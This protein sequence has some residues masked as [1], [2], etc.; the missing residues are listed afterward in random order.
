MVRKWALAMSLV[1]VTAMAG[2]G[3][4]FAL[5]TDT[6]GPVERQIT[7]GTLRIEGNRDMGDTVPGPLF[8]ISNTGD[9]M[10]EDGL[11]GIHET[12][13]WAP[14]DKHER[15]FQ[16]ENVGTLDAKLVSLRAELQSGSQE[17]IDVLQVRVT[18]DYDNLLLSGTLADFV[19]ADQFFSPAI[20]LAVWDNVNLYI[21]VE[22]P[23]SAG[24]DL[25]GETA[26]VKFSA[27]AEQLRNN[28]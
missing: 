9:G 13:L 8:Y 1:G 15:V 27:Y 23:L 19:A 21:E 7:A 26:V 24:N 5:F 4:T 2:A 25:Q 14:G 6:A 28:P 18:D 12:G 3:I 16:I 20:E 22:L 11:P 17:L 10:S